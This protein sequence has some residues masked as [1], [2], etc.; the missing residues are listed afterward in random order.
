MMPTLG[1][2]RPV[3]EVADIIRRHGTAFHEQFGGQLAA[4]QRKALRDLAACRTARLGGHVQRCLDCDH[5]RVAYNSCRN[6][7][8][9]K[10]QAAARAAWLDREAGYL[11][12]V[13]YHHV[14]FTLP[15][16][17][18]ELARAHPAAVYDLLFRAA[19]ATLR[20]VAANP[21]RLGAAVGVLAVL[22]TWGQNLQ[23]HPHLHCVVT[24]GGLSCDAGG[25][26]DARRAGWRAGRGS[27]CRSGCS[28]RSSAASSWR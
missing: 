16:A 28:A 20:D 8:C 14:V 19:S 26:I 10:C 5:E 11:L 6:R 22:H 25:R 13:E 21:R 7:H 9:P 23:H 15:R 24:G 3:W 17:V 12:P 1:T 4:T 2:D 27:S 18:A